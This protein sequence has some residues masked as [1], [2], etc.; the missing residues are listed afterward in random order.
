MEPAS[1][2]AVG[3]GN[4]VRTSFVGRELPKPP[5]HKCP[6]NTAGS[7]CGATGDVLTKVHPETS[8]P[9]LSTGCRPG[10]PWVPDTSACR[11]QRGFCAGA[12][13]AGPHY[14]ALGGQGPGTATPGGRV[15]RRASAVC[16][17]SALLLRTGRPPG[18]AR[19]S[20]PRICF[21][22]PSRG[23]EWQH[24]ASSV[25]GQPAG[26]SGGQPD[27]GGRADRP[28]ASATA[29]L[30]APLALGF[31]GEAAVG[32]APRGRQEGREVRSRRRRPASRGL[33]PVGRG[34]RPRGGCASC[35]WLFVAA[36][37]HEHSSAPAVSARQ[38]PGTAMREGEGTHG[39][40]APWGRVDGLGEADRPSQDEGAAVCP[41][42]PRAPGCPRRGHST[43]ALPAAT[44]RREGRP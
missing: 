43:D 25:P 32:Q 20:T 30:S 39:P 7:R 37:S 21:S 14:F 41:V 28:A 15:A 17:Q 9:G 26:A 13:G 34:G 22:W 11:R 18:G 42:C 29:P 2:V 16:P 24:Q 44:G 3:R 35:T 1:S 31:A 38:G 12:G 23:R 33:R 40:A 27:R 10:R 6:W 36:F 4:P 5:G 19:G 8:D